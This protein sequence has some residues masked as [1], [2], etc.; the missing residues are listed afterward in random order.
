LVTAERA[1][2]WVLPAQASTATTHPFLPFPKEF[3]VA[4]A[5][6]ELPDVVTF[7]L[8]RADENDL[9]SIAQAMNRR[10][11]ELRVIVDAT[12]T[13]GDIT[14]R[15]LAGLSG[16]VKAITPGRVRYVTL[17]LDQAST[18]KLAGSATTYAHLAGRDSYD[19]AGVPLS[20]CTVTSA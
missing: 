8:E 2:R 5:P 3:V 10:R 7:V 11:Q 18:N 1:D 4:T 13:I 12:V 19:L 16:V 14:P 20:C 17:S 15:Y 9:D 6:V